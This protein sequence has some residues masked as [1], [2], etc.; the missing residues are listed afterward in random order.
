MGA[1][2]TLLAALIAL[3]AGLAAGKA[4]ERYKLVDGRIVDRRRQRESP[5]YL[6]GLNFLGSNQTDLAIE[7]LTKA[8]A[9]HCAKHGYGIRVNSVH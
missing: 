9:L 5:H 4:W 1:Y 3:L 7:E 6:L 8:A 2:A